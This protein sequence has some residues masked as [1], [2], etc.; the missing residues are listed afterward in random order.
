MKN[1]DRYLKIAETAKEV[2]ESMAKAFRQAES[3]GYAA[4]ERGSSTQATVEYRVFEDRFRIHIGGYSIGEIH[5]Y[6]K[7]VALREALDMAVDDL[8]KEEADASEVVF[9]T[10]MALMEKAL[11]PTKASQ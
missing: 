3:H 9:D 8:N 6:P 10:R 5:G 4:G 11:K 7:L 1:L 2:N